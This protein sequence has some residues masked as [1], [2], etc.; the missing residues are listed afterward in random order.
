[1]LNYKAIALLV[2]QLILVSTTDS[3]QTTN[4]WTP[5]KFLG[6]AASDERVTAPGS[7]G[8]NQ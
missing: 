7:R 6:A 8:P 5:S 3:A 1:M 4:P 2:S